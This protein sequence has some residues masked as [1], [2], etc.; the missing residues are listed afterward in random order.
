MSEILPSSVSSSINEEPRF[1][2]HNHSSSTMREQKQHPSSVNIINKYYGEGGNTNSE[3]DDRK[4]QPSQE[5]DELNM[6]DH[7]NNEKE[8]SRNLFNN[9][10]LNSNV[11]GGEEDIIEKSQQ[12]MKSIKN[13]QYQQGF[14]EVKAIEPSTTHS[15]TQETI[16][17]Y[18]EPK[19]EVGFDRF[20][21]ESTKN[22]ASKKNNIEQKKGQEKSTKDSSQTQTLI[23]TIFS[24]FYWIIGSNQ[25]VN[26]DKKQKLQNAN[27]TE[28]PQTQES[29][30]TSGELT[31]G[32]KE[33]PTAVFPSKKPERTGDSSSSILSTIFSTSLFSSSGNK[34]QD[35]KTEPKRDESKKESKRKTSGS[36][37]KWIER[38]GADAG[39]AA[40]NAL[41]DPLER[42]ASSPVLATGEV[43]VVHS[44]DFDNIDF[45]RIFKYFL[46]MVF[47][48]RFSHTFFGTLL[49]ALLGIRRRNRARSI[50]PLGQTYVPIQHITTI[51]SKTKGAPSVTFIP[52]NHH[53]H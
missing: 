50:E 6:E 18:T 51:P 8:F 17:S 43:I 41:K 44:L 28:K 47:T 52:P 32:E 35:E 5:M 10:N 11:V 49:P 33:K 15:T 31:T 53:H 2:H 9:D 23:D 25:N 37:L 39:K 13:G 1:Y 22:M 21:V 46:F 36:P 34:K 26:N 27:A 12:L 7:P 30:E 20:S 4:Q 45:R 14:S 3:E 16:E 38:F 29:K 19:R 24:P 40:S 42:L 48:W